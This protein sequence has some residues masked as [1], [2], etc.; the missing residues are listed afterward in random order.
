M[1]TKRK[2]DACG[3][4][5]MM[6][7]TRKKCAGCRWFEAKIANGTIKKPNYAEVNTSGY[8]EPMEKVEGGFGYYGAV[9]ETNDGELIQC[10]ICGYYYANVGAHVR[11]KHG[12]ASRDYKLKY[13]LRIMDGLVSKNQR[14]RYQAQYNST[15]RKTRADYAAMSAKGAKV[16][17]KKGYKPGGDMWNAQTRNEKGMCKEQTI[18]KIK[19]LAEMTNNRPTE[20]AF[21]RE[22]GWGQR[23]V[24]QH[25]F[26]SWAAAMEELGLPTWREIKASDWV[27]RKAKALDDIYAFY[28]AEHRTP[29]FSD[30]K[31]VSWLPDPKSVIKYFGSLNN[32]RTLAQVPVLVH[33]GGGHWVEVE[34]M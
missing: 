4:Q 28:E 32:A 26:G 14:E 15:N 8:K 22:F 9:T 18:A 17:K 1:R 16:M 6:E 10:H 21:C 12:V 11:F 7:G 34:T 30:F 2:C 25:W 33:Q 20:N 23:N 29:Q 3:N 5:R 13:G 24:V 31:A 19:R 27:E